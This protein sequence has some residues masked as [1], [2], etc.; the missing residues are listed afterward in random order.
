M[1]VLSPEGVGM[2]LA[3]RSAHPGIAPDVLRS[4][5][6]FSA[7]DDVTLAA[8]ARQFRARRFRRHEVI[9]HE[10]DPGDSLFVV[11]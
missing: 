11:A 4:C 3:A 7:M 1:A 5:A 10:G 2:I 6:L 8:V 9:F